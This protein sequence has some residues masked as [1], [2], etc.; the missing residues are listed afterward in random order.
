M[1]SDIN[2]RLFTPFFCFASKHRYTA[3]LEHHITVKSWLND[4]HALIF[5]PR[6]VIIWIAIY[7][8]VVLMW[9]INKT[10]FH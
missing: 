3:F 6:G 10:L 2:C 1:D 4:C 5:N 9:K 7:C 8:E